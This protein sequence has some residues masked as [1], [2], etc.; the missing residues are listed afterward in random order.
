[1]RTSELGFRIKELGFQIK[2]SVMISVLGLGLELGVRRRDKM[3]NAA[4]QCDS[5]TLSRSYPLGDVVFVD[6]LV[7]WASLWDFP[8][9]RKPL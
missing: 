8:Q 1:M 5:A 7:L 2:V 6:C 3:C 9:P 4:S